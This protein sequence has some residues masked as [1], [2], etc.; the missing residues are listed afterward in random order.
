[1]RRVHA[2]YHNLY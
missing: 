1:M 2:I